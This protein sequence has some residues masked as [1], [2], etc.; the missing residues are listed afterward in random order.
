MCK[1][2]FLSCLNFFL[3][4]KNFNSFKMLARSLEAIWVHTRKAIRYGTCTEISMPN[5]YINN[6][7]WASSRIASRAQAT[8]DSPTRLRRFS[9]VH[10]RSIVGVVW[11]FL[12]VS[13]HSLPH[14]PLS[15]GALLSHTTLRA[16][17]KKQRACTMYLNAHR[18]SRVGLVM[19]NAKKQKWKK[20]K[21]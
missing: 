17:K 14:T 11:Y 2:E 12:V 16:E 6:K 21:S 9:L 10:S 13:S 15:L 18:Q 8:L 1:R 19:Q 4:S 20:E 3:L 5:N 7:Q